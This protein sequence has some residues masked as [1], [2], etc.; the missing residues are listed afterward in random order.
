MSAFSVLVLNSPSIS[1]WYGF[2]A[3]SVRIDLRTGTCRTA[4]PTDLTSLVTIRSAPTTKVRFGT[5]RVV[6]CPS[7]KRRSSISTERPS[8]LRGLKACVEN[9][10]PPVV[11]SGTICTGTEQYLSSFQLWSIR[12]GATSMSGVQN[13]FRAREHLSFHKS[14]SKSKRQRESCI[15]LRLILLTD[16]TIVNVD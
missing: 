15:P 14:L 8:F 13:S 12:S 3:R 5:S 2:G 1:A 6:G 16:A 7:C 11:A 4:N 9:L 10:K